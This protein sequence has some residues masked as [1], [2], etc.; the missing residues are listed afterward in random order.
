[1]KS[2]NKKTSYN[3]S[4]L[5]R[6]KANSDYKDALKWLHELAEEVRKKKEVKLAG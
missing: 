3:T 2:K 6:E 1:M 4:D 5:K